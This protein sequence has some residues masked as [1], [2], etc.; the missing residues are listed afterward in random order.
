ME[1]A[2]NDRDFGIDDFE[3]DAYIDWWECKVIYAE[4]GWMGTYKSKSDLI[5]NMF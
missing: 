4:T 3:L 5:W 1:I 2:E